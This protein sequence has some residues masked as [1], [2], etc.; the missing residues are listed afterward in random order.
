MVAV[1]AGGGGT[2]AALQTNSHGSGGGGLRYTNNVDIDGGADYTIVV[3]AGGE[4]VTS[5][6]NSARTGG[7]SYVEDS[8]GTKLVA[9]TGGRGYYDGSEHTL[10][11]IHI[12][13]PTR[14]Y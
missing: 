1:G 2:I 9:V 10:S 12:S 6:T 8:D 7:S 11:L 14:P 13:E 3:G 5:N 4:T